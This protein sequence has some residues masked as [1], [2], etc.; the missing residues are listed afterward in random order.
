MSISLSIFLYLYYAFLVSWVFFSLVGIYHM[1]KFGFK[2]FGAF[3]VTF[4]FIA[5]AGLIL[6]ISFD[7]ISQ[8]DW[9]QPVVFFRGIFSDNKFIDK[10][11]NF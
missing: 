2:S 3:I 8:V 1:I 9:S 6:V 11:I 5:I 4:S 7:Y 10:S